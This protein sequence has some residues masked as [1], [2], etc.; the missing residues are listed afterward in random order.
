MT[1]SS[2]ETDR[3]S[4]VEEFY[5]LLRRLRV[6]C[7]GGRQL[8]D[9]SGRSGWPRRGLYWFFEPGETRVLGKELRVVRVGTHGL[10]VGSRTTL[11]TRLAQH[12]GQVGGSQPG[13][14]N[15]RGSVFRR[16]VGRAL[17]NRDGDQYPLTIR[18]SWGVGSTA[19]AATRRSEYQLEQVVSRYIRGMP[20]LWLEVADDPGPASLRGFLE[21]NA[22]GL[23]SHRGRAFIDPPSPGWLG[24]HADAA[25]IRESGLWNVN[26]VDRLPDVDFLPEFAKA[27]GR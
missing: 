9:C 10:G 21:A 15:H 6:R 7:G 4:L 18:Q 5:E 12:R 16:H 22:V 24:R 1:R 19:D 17:L 2:P 3:T 8:R 13:G 11:W 23:L 25:A 14:G 27:I 26:H 20:F